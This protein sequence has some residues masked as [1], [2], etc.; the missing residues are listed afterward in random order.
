MCATGFFYGRKGVRYTP[1]MSKYF[2][3]SGCAARL[4]G[5][6]LSLTTLASFAVEPEGGAGYSNCI[7]AAEHEAITR[8]HTELGALETR[9]GCKELVQFNQA[10]YLEKRDLHRKTADG[11]LSAEA[12]REQL[13]IIELKEKTYLDETSQLRERCTEPFQ[14]R[15]ALKREVVLRGRCSLIPDYTPG[16]KKGDP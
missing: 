3:F 7:T 6:T 10:I 9:M 12:Y 2:F 8:R 5:F 13:S 1:A 14:E 4:C 15:M 16:I 11:V